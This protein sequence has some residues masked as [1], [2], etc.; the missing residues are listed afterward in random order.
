MSSKAPQ[1]TCLESRG[2]EILGMTS[3][4][5]VKESA[6]LGI[7]KIDAIAVPNGMSSK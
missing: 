7:P 1:S 5:F 4:A 2:P 3:D 6:V